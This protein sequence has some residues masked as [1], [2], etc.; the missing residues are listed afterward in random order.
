M[1][2]MY[3][4]RERS[5][6]RVQEMT[7]S[8]HY[9]VGLFYT[10]IDM[11]LQ[12]LNNHFDEVSIEFLLCVACLNPSSSF[13]SFYKARLIQFAKFYSK[14][15]PDVELLALSD[16]LENFVTNVH[17]SVDFLDLKGINDLAQKM[18]ETRKIKDI[19]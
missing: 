5:R 1:N 19:I 10:V 11:Q 17:T 16:Q 3:V 12:K 6:R 2:D 15:F 18:V 14:D 13:A 4:P 8:H 7:N 9:Q